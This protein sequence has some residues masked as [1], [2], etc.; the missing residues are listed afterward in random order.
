VLREVCGD[1]RLHYEMTREL[2]SVERQQRA[3]ARRANLFD[4]LEKSIRR[5]YYD[6]KDDAT[7]MARRHGQARTAA[8]KGERATVFA[9]DPEAAPD[10]IQPELL[11]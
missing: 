3:H 2:L 7:D 5:H 10:A 11:P 8:S 1:D 6:D 9:D 4:Q